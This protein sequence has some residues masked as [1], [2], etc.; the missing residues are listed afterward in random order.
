M[1]DQKSRKI[2]FHSLIKKNLSDTKQVPISSWLLGCAMNEVEKARNP[3]ETNS[4]GG[5]DR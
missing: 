3:Q 2:A 4:C 1:I 5:G